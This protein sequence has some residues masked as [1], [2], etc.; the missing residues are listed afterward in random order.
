[1]I[2]TTDRKHI[3][4]ARAMALSS[5]ATGWHHPAGTRAQSNLFFGMSVLS[6]LLRLRSG[7]IEQPEGTAP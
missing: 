2:V 4:K 6:E 1:M 7:V 3:N 5:T